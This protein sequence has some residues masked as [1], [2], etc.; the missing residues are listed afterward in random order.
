MFRPGLDVP[1]KSRRM[2]SF[3]LCVRCAVANVGRRLKVSA[4]HNGDDLVSQ[5]YGAKLDVPRN[6]SQR[7]EAAQCCAVLR[8]LR[9]NHAAVLWLCMNK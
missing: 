5:G 4:D 9:K 3:D 2:M 6:Q 7:S 1:T 8:I